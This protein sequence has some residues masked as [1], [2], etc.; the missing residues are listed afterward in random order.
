MEKIITD[1]LVIG[2]GLAGE[3]AAVEAVARGHDVTVL[4]L[5]PAKRSH[6]CAAQGG[7]QAALGNTAMAKGDNPDV[8]FA[9]TVK[10]SD[11]GADQDRIRLFCDSMPWIVRQMD[12]W[13]VPWNR[14]VAGPFSFHKRGKVHNVEDTK[15]KEGLITQRDFGGVSHWRCAY[16]SDGTGHTLL[17]AMDN[18]AAELGVKVVDRVEVVGLIHDGERCLGAVVRDLR[19]GSLRPYLAKATVIAT[20]GFGRI[21]GKSTNA[22]QNEGGGLICAIDTGKV[23]LGNMEA[24]QF[25][26]TAIVPV[27]I[28]ITEGCRG[29]G[30]YLMD[31]DNHRF[32][33]DYEPKKQELASRDVV[34]RAMLKH[35]R[36]GK[37]AEGPYG[38]HIWLDLRHLGRKHLE[39]K[40]RE[41]TDIARNFVGID[42]VTEMVPVL[43]TQHYSMGGV[44]TDINCAAYGLKGLY[45]AG[46]SAC[47]DMHGFNRLGG[48]SLAETLVTGWVAGEK[49]CDYIEKDEGISFPAKVVEDAVREQQAK[50]DALVNRSNGGTE[51][52]Y[53]IRT[54]MEQILQENVG[55]FRNGEGLQKA[56]DGL[57]ELLAASKK[58]KLRSSGKYANP[59][60][61][62]ALKMPGM[63]KIA[64]CIAYGGLQRTESRGSHY[65]EDFP[66]R[67]D[68]KWLSRTL[69]TWKNADDEVPTL[70]YEKPVI[71]DIPPGERGYGESKVVKAGDS[72]EKK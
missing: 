7:M 13:G 31:K 66:A 40:L 52:V 34:S 17:Y 4:S 62:L 55:I 69:A 61:A 48:N 14:V 1:V 35:I 71:T 60:V 33:A 45:A 72:Q 26:P 58:I 6:S 11:W 49:L 18:R 47:W 30:G 41:V 27:W 44:R 36:D 20:G 70:E 8:H 46:E 21:Y 24:V 3:R 9:D 65:R 25:H 29:D 63:V 42:P 59:E 67:N 68:E 2:G 5:I 57:K 15:D 12:A 64:L 28:L 50:I 51:N 23:P 10:G 19:D 56:V 53:E 43:P 54:K 38:A 37:G 39:T 32:M 16:T 22:I